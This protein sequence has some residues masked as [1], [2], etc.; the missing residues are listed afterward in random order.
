M[1]RKP[2]KNFWKNK[3]VYVTGHTGFKGSWLVSWLIMLGAK[4][5]G[6]SLPLDETNYLFKKIKDSIEGEITSQYGNILDKESLR[7]SINEFQPDIIFHLAAQPLVLK[8]Y[9]DPI[10]TWE[11]N[12]IG[13]LNVLN[14]LKEIKKSC[15]FIAITTDKVYKNK[16]W[17]YGY[18]EN[19]E[20][21]GHDPYSASKAACEIAISSWRESF[22]NNKKNNEIKYRIASARAGNV[23]GGGDWAVNRIV[24]DSIKSLISNKKIHVRNPK[25]KR[26]WQHVLEPLNGYLLLGEKLSLQDSRFYGSFNFGPNPSNNKSVE[27]IVEKILNYWEGEWIIDEDQNNS[28]EAKL[29]SLQIDKS[30]DLIGWMPI[31]EFDKTIQVTVN[32]YKNV[33]HGNDPYDELVKNI[34]EFESYFQ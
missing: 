15:S 7:K 28:H 14:C 17:I 26:P 22:V 27:Q 2:N 5:K 34:I 24:P 18:R 23:L 30:I 19:D 4:V 32:W 1:V 21:G 9:L 12:V 13:T 6:Y 8:S 29:L 33:N 3:K 11:T 16:E 20:L 10:G 31:W 25:S